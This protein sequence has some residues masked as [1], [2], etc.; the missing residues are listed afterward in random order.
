MRPG[1]WHSFTVVLT[2]TSRRPFSFGRGC[3]A[4]TEQIDAY[5]AQAYVLNCRAVGSIAPRS[6]VRFAMRIF[7]P[8]RSASTAHPAS[9]GWT[10]APHTWNAPQSA[11]AILEV[12]R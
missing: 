11:P 2:N 1:S 5:P 12:T 4:Y 8:P 9:L 10:L 3:P 6:S 7:V